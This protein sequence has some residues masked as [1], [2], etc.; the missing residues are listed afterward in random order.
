[1]LI[2]KR[3]KNCLTYGPTWTYLCTVLISQKI[4]QTI[5]SFFVYLNVQKT[6]DMSFHH[7]KVLIFKRRRLWKPSL[8]LRLF[9]LELSSKAGHSK[10]NY[11]KSVRKNVFF[12]FLGLLPLLICTQFLKNQF[13]KIKFGELD[14]YCLCSLQKSILKLIFSG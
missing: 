11:K 7:Y 2:W 5:C 3:R 13:G 12:S 14:F 1:M 8:F 10:E 9:M 4:G 6:L